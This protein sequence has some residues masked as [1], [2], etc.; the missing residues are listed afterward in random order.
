MVAKTGRSSKLSTYWARSR[1]R[2]N[3]GPSESVNEGSALRFT[4]TP[5]CVLQPPNSFQSRP[6]WPS[7]EIHFRASVLKPALTPV[8]CGFA[9]SGPPRV[10]RSSSARWP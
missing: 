4:L 8:P 10:N 3:W 5:L 6:P 1:D 7:S 2:T 9:A